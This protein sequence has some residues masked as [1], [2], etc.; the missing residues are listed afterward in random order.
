VQGSQSLSWNHPSPSQSQKEGKI[1]EL[2]CHRIHLHQHLAPSTLFP[3]P[4]PSR[5]SSLRWILLLVQSS[6]VSSSQLCAF[7]LSF[8]LADNDPGQPRGYF[9]TSVVGTASYLFERQVLTHE[10]PVIYTIRTSR[11]THYSSKASWVSCGMYL[12][13]FSNPLH[14]YHLQYRFLETLHLAIAASM[15]YAYV[16]TYGVAFFHARPRPHQ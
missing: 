15:Q 4:C 16:I 10:S 9:D 1:T 12:S 7:S 5:L 8:P 2:D 13:I 11:R 3:P 14:P 6:L